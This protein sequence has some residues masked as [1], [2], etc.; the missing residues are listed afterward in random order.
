M[1]SAVGDRGMLGVELFFF[2][3]YT[4]NPEIYTLAPHDARPM[5]VEGGGLEGWRVGGWG[6]CLFSHIEPFQK[7]KKRERWIHVIQN[8]V[9]DLLVE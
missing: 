7:K 4:E 3:N 6:L 8:I 9:V 5:W 1:S 2:F